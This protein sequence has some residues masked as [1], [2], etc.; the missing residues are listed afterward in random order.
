[1]Y[2]LVRHKTFNDK[3]RKLRIT[4]QLAYLNT[5]LISISRTAAWTIGSLISGAPKPT[6]TSIPPGFVDWHKNTSITDTKSTTI[7]STWW[8][9]EGV[10]T[11]WL[12]THMLWYRNTPTISTSLEDARQTGISTFLG[13]RPTV[14]SL[15][16]L[17]IAYTN[18]VA[19]QN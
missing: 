18:V 10:V 1:M 19:H 3:S 15:P 6:N 2:T 16:P 13:P 11:L 17:R 7:G 9:G 5:P 4:Y 8:E 14:A 12:W